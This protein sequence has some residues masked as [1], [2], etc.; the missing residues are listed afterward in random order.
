MTLSPLPDKVAVLWPI[1][2]DELIKVPGW[3]KRQDESRQTALGNNTFEV[4]KVK[5]LSSG[6]PDFR[7][8]ET[9]AV[10]V[11]ASAL[12]LD[13][14]DYP[15]LVPQGHEVR[16]YGMFE[17]MVDGVRGKGRKARVSS[18]DDVALFKVSA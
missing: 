2:T 9:I 14:L 17:D 16:I 3:V 7:E 6:H 18:F 13:H 1:E 10:R 8:G 12:I 11:D 15:A 5:V 4:R